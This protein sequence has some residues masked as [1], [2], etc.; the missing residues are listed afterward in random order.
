MNYFIDLFS[1]E[2]ATAFEQSKRDISGFRISQKTYV[3]NQSIG[4]GDKFICYVTRL[5]RFVGILEIKSKSFTDDKS[6]FQ[7]ENDPFVL[8][9]KVNPLVWLPLT[10]AI[11]IRDD[12]IWNR[13]SF[14]KDLPKESNH[15]TYMV[16]SSPRL[17]PKSDCEFLEKQLL[18][19]AAQL[20]D[21]PFTEEDEKKLKSPK[22]RLSGK[23]EIT[24]SIPD[25]EAPNKPGPS[26]TVL[27]RES[28]RVQ[29]TL[30]EIGEK[31]GF[32]IWLPRNDRSQIQEFWKAKED[33]L[34]DALPFSFDDVTLRTIKNI[35]LLWV[36][37]RTI[38][39]A[40]EVE[41]TTSIY[42][43][44]LRMADLLSLLPNIDISIH[45]V[46]PGGRRNEVFKQ[47]SRPVFAV[48][49]KGPLAELCSYI[50]Y[51]SVYE[52]AKEKQLK[53]MTDSILDEY[54][55]FAEE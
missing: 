46:A 36:R 20:L 49:E 18:K 38:V 31:L 26:E 35:D 37:G 19:Q 1:P 32:K 11:P 16:F 45:I 8:R 13:L 5:Q 9:F 14:T 44:I 7:E 52:L 41:G 21:Y 55:E 25:E 40:F 43:G 47:I 42:S 53:Y 28:I 4:L 23:K 24:V 17:W 22:I 2:T 34:L 50:S 3:E 30:S 10:K 54:S 12:A 15:W 39:R 33:V 51:E 27:E 29:A 48:M 6:I